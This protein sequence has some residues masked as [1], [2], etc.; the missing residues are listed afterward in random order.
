MKTLLCGI[1][2]SAAAMAVAAVPEVSAVSFSQSS[3]TRLVTIDYALDAQAV[4][5]VDIQTNAEEGVWASIGAENFANV[6]GDVNRRVTKDT[7]RITWDPVVSWPDHKVATGKMRAVVTAWALDNTPDYMVVDLA[8]NSDRRIRYFVST[9]ALPGG[10]LA[11]E[12]YRTKLLVMRR[13]HA[14]DVTYSMGSSCELGRQGG[15]AR[16]EAARLVTLTNDFYLAVFPTTQSQWWMTYTDTA[17]KAQC[18]V[19]ETAMRPMENITFC[20]VREN[21]GSSQNTAYQYPKAPHP[22]SWLGLTRTRTTCADFPNGLDLDL[23]SEAQWEYAA[24]AGHGDG[25]WGNGAPISSA[26]NDP[27]MPGRCRH[28]QQNPD[29]QTAAVAPDV[30]G[31]AIVGTHAPNS[32]GFYD[33]HGNVWEF[34]LDWLDANGHNDPSFHGQ[35][36]AD[37]TTWADGTTAGSTRVSMGGSWYG[38]AGDCRSASYIARDPTKGWSFVGMRVACRAGLK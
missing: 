13:V 16:N 15:N 7:G 27:N 21:S 35:C 1:A 11:N 30:G 10:L 31:T 14:K 9:N 5:T 18:N 2:A 24:R 6:Q 12:D 20:R 19:G 3:A 4:V 28:E 17:V 34:G 36:N 38:E 23:P 8:Q 25:Y 22:S 29:N 26:T 33:M 37:G 32:W